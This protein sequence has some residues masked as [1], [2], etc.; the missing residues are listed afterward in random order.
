M[1]AA[2]AQLIRLPEVKRRTGLSRS[3]IYKRERDGAFPR[4]INLSPRCS[5]WIAGEIETWI[6][7]QIEAHRFN[8][9]ELNGQQPMSL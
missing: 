6:A 2:A 4:H 8:S 7:A 1:T 9:R 3:T 5:V